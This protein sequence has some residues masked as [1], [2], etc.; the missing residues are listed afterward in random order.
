MIQRHAD[1]VSNRWG[2]MQMSFELSAITSPCPI[3]HQPDAYIWKKEAVRYNEN[4][5]K[6]IGYWLTL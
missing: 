2:A 4:Q 5:N 1:T 3:G 6:I